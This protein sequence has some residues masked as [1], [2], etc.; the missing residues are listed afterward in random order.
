MLRH[1]SV[2]NYALIARLDM[3]LDENLNIITGETG[4]GKSILLGALGLLLGD[5]NESAPIKDNTQNCKIEGS[6]DISSLGLEPLFD[7]HDIDYLPQ[8]TITRIITP[9]GK[10]RSF[11]ND[12][13]VPLSALKILGRELIDIH[14]QNQNQILS[15]EQFRL[16]ALDT[17]ANNSE[18]L[19]R[20]SEHYTKYVELRGRLS[21]LEREA[22]ELQQ[23]E[24]FLR[25]QVEE[26]SVAHL[27]EG[28]QAELEQELSILQ[29]AD[30]L[31][32]NFTLLRNILDDDAMGVLV[33]LKSAEGAML[34]VGEHYAQAKEYGDRL[35]SVIEELKD[36]SASAGSDSERIEADPERLTKLSTRLDVLLTL[37]H[38]HRVQSESELIE[39]R[40]NYIERLGAITH[41]GEQLELVRSLVEREKVEAQALADELHEVRKAVC[42]SFEAECCA[43]LARLGMAEAALKVDL[44]RQQELTPT[45]HNGVEFL[46]SSNANSTPQSIERIASGG[47]RSRVMLSIKAMLAR[48]MTLPTII[49]DEI[50]SGVSG[51]IADA[52]G[53]IIA[54]LS[55]TM[56]VVDITHL[57]QVASKGSTHFVVYKDSG[58]S[59]IKLLSDSERIEEIAKMLSGAQISEQAISQAKILLGS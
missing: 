39:V 18:L 2:E 34:Q 35:R 47:E 23:N 42:D 13:P 58:H 41:N 27:Q 48:R 36:V 8:T 53:E 51:R 57:P 4:A 50:D 10:S 38:K 28:E 44:L 11:V 6:F 59:T 16:S 32:E 19:A 20:Y 55:T 31:S 33:Q 45:G 24:E 14:S 3:E 46:F 26:L 15:S 30:R 12:V 54:E 25:Y 1:L 56:Q 5:R 9:A 17:L 21:K 49:F 40:D 22:V 43:T 37:Q 52:M 29:N 7:E